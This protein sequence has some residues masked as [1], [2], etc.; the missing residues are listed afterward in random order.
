MA[1]SKPRALRLQV[2]GMS[3]IGCEQRIGT[4]LR[5]LDGVVE[6]SADHLT[7]EVRVRFDPTGTDRG[8]LVERIVLAGYTVE[9]DNATDTNIDT[10]NDSVPVE[11]GDR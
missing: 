8:A 5:R 11:R 3:C 2:Q 9:A 10:D 4:A 1:K 6:A 7:G